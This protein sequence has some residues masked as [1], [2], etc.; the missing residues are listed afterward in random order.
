VAGLK[1]ILV[2]EDDP[3]IR[4]M[5]RLALSNQ[6]Y[7]VEVADSADEM[8]AKLKDF[9]PDCIFLDVMLPNTSG[10]EILTELRSNEELG[11]THAK[12]VV[13]TN[14]AQRSVADNA[15][16][17]GADGFIIKAEILPKDLAKVIESLEEE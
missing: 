14:L 2:I 15:M 1:N 11:C 8:Y 6:Q 4:E 13:L 16:E 10:L 9:K 3:S 17:N 7:D 12:I 5:Y